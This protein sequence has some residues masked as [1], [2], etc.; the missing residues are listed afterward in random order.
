VGAIDDGPVCEFGPYQVNVVGALAFGFVHQLVGALNEIAGKATRDEPAV[1]DAS[2]PEAHHA[3]VH[4]NWLPGEAP[5]L[6]RPGVALHRFAKAFPDG[7]RLMTG[8][9]VWREETE[10]VAAEARVEVLR[11]RAR[12]TFLRQQIV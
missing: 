1:G 11:T 3:D 8:G 12:R 6:K 5:I 2:E 7:V 9:Q 4:P 10:L